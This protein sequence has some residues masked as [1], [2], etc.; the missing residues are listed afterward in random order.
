MERDTS[1]H[2]YVEA[3]NKAVHGHR[4][5]N[6]GQVDHLFGQSFGFIAKDHAQWLGILRQCIQWYCIWRDCCRCDLKPSLV[7]KVNGR[8]RRLKDV[9]TQREGAVISQR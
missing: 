4:E 9:L 8:L 7:V 2:R 1:S 6:V 3:L 5:L